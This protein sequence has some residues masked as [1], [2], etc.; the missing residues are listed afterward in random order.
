VLF[1]PCG[2]NR[3][4]IASTRMFLLK[5]T[6]SIAKKNSLIDPN[7]DSGIRPE[8]PAK[9]FI[10]LYQKFATTL[11]FSFREEEHVLPTHDI[12]I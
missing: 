5:K 4:S 2:V 8:H 7:L 1:Q 3:K 11:I 10:F 9:K 12:T 6:A